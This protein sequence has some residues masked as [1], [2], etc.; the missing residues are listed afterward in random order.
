[1]NSFLKQLAHASRN[2]KKRDL[3][4]NVCCKKIK[5]SEQMRRKLYSHRH[6]I[7][8]LANKKKLTTLRGVKTRLVQQGGFLATLLP[9]IVGSLLGLIAGRGV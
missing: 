1:M 7:R 6:T 8:D 2:K 5:L 9:H 3:C 4:Y